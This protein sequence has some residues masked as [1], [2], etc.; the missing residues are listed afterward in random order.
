[1]AAQLWSE[2]RCSRGSA[3]QSS[4]TRS[5]PGRAKVPLYRKCTQKRLKA[6]FCSNHEPFYCFW[7]AGIAELGHL[8][9]RPPRPPRAPGRGWGHAAAR[10]VKNYFRPN[11]PWTLPDASGASFGKAA[12]I[13]TS[14]AAQH[15]LQPL[16]HS[17]EAGLDWGT[18][19]K[20]SSTCR[21]RSKRRRSVLD[22]R[23]T[24][25]GASAT[26]RRSPT[27]QFP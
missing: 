20:P 27:S 14:K 4:S 5:R 6:P 2:S 21:Q 10:G 8:K 3:G 23:T 24:A 19:L 18:L 13:I 7:R 26:S 9:I 12:T 25:V 15:C 1:M 22:G 16:S 11:S 17:A